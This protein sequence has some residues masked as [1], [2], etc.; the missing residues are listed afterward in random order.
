MALLDLAVESIGTRVGNI[1]GQCL[2][3]ESIRFNLEQYLR[4]T[5]KGVLEVAKQ[6]YDIYP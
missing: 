1:E 5:R 4:R 3:S 2:A 6:R